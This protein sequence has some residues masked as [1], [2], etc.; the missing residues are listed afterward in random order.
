MS[1]SI[2]FPADLPIPLRDSYSETFEEIHRNL[3]MEVG[4][5]RRRARMRTAPRRFSLSLTLSQAEFATFDSWWQFTILGGQREFDIQLLD[6]DDIDPLV[7]Y[8]V[9]VVD[10]EYSLNVT[11][12]FDYEV[13]FSVRAVGASFADRPSG[14]DTLR[15]YNLMGMQ[16]VKGDLLV[17]TPYRGNT[18]IGIT[19]ARAVGNLQPLR[20]GASFYMLARGRL[21]L[22]PMGG[23]A[24]IGIIAT[25]RFDDATLVYYPEQ[26]RQWQQFGWMRPLAAQDINISQELVSREFSEI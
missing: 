22:P 5:A 10:G 26:S 11:Q 4:T 25:A 1:S 23:N 18:S 3:A 14:T 9:H 8:T 7:W 24:S 15:G 12:S 21:L 13:S 19:Y 17:F 20:G 16:A 6:E 2:R